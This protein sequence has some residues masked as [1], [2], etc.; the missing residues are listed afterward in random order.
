MDI[1]PQYL[2]GFF[3]GEGSIYT[4]STKTMISPYASLTNVRK[5]VLDYC[6]KKYGG[7][8][9]LRK[10]KLESRQRDIWNWCIGGSNA[11]VFLRDIVDY[12]VLKKNRAL[13]VLKWDE[14]RPGRNRWKSI[15]PEFHRLMKDYI[16]AANKT[17]KVPLNAN[18]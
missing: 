16:K 17:G 14:L 9:N 7:N 6:H 18:I 11:A 15:N 1:S 4:M 12:L 8:L 2:A 3:D 10:R 13:L 5:E